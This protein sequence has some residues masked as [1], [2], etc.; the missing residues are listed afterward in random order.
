MA[1]GTLTQAHADW[2][3]EG[4]DQGFW[5]P[6]ADQAGFGLGPRGDFGSPHGGFGGPRG[7]FG[8]H[9]F[10]RFGTAPTPTPAP[11]S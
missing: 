2:L 8:G 7:G 1:D 6:A 9:G 4:L 11:S 3:N 5:G 10:G